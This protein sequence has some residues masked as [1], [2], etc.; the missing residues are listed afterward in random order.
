MY[1]WFAV[2]FLNNPLQ[3]LIINEKSEVSL[4]YE[5]C[6]IVLQVRLNHIVDA[7][8]FYMRVLEHEMPDG[9]VSDFSGAYLELLMAMA[10]YFNVRKHHR[11]LSTWLVN[12]LTLLSIVISILEMYLKFRVISRNIEFYFLHTR[13]GDS[14]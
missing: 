13:V 1:Y 7:N 8:H 2:Q 6:N 4:K 3:S 14:R 9:T 11:S 12:Y 10:H 5:Y